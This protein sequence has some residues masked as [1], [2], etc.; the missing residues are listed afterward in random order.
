[1]SPSSNVH[2]LKESRPLETTRRY[3]HSQV[4]IDPKLGTSTL[5]MQPP[6]RPC[7][8]PELLSDITMWQ[9]GFCNEVRAA[10]AEGREPATRYAVL[11]SGM[12]QF[13]NCGGDLDHFIDCIR[14]QDRG[15]LLEY[16]TDCISVAH[17]FS[18]SFDLPVTT[19]AL[20]RGPA[21]GG[22]FEAALSANVI[23]AERGVQMGFPEVLFNLFP[24]MGAYS[25]LSRRV[26]PGI[27]ERLILS[28]QTYGAEELYEMGIVNVLA[29]PG[30]GERALADYVRQAE[31]TTNAH[32]LIRKARSKF[33]RVPYAELLEITQDWV[34]CALS[35]SE[36]DLKVMERLVRRQTQKASVVQ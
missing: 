5:Y 1:M 24:G 18:I 23:V 32:G 2:V 22:G 28:G 12:D 16:A 20:V 19:I 11:A 14:T 17:R 25:F 4:V 10:M 15:R 26:A 34:E 8:T 30:D 35:L 9:D 6:F 7:Y 31:R 27:A 3:R 36:R 21:L 33:N 13:F 29:A